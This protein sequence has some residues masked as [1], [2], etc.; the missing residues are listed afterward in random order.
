MTISGTQIGM[1]EVDTQNLIVSLENK[2]LLY[3]K[4]SFSSGNPILITGS[5]GSG[6]TTLVKAILGIHKIVGGEINYRKEG[7]RGKKIKKSYVPQYPN[8]IDGN[9]IQNITLKFDKFDPDYEKLETICD[10]VGL[11]KNSI[12]EIDPLR[13]LDN[14]DLDT[15]GGQR[16]RISI[17]RALYH[18]ADIVLFDEPVASLDENLGRSI[19]RLII[20]ISKSKAVLVVSHNT[21]VFSNITNIMSLNT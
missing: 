9:L 16:Q 4:F 15:S 8:L 5:S 10:A 14:N 17:A 6:K 13:N 3:H 20:E 18:D 2:N 7:I 11:I 21:Q 1:I 19:A 12:W